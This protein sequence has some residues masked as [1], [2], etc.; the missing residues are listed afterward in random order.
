MR[1]C[2]NGESELGRG[3]GAVLVTSERQPLP[4]QRERKEWVALA[5][6]GVTHSAIGVGAD[7]MLPDKTCGTHKLHDVRTAF[8]HDVIVVLG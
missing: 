3:E 2:T 1:S 4:F 5:A 6:T 7:A 8:C